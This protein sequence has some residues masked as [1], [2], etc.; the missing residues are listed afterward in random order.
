[1]N[2]FIAQQGWQCPICKTVYSPNT[3]MCYYCNPGATKT[4]TSA[5]DIRWVDKLSVDADGNVR[6]FY[7]N[8]KFNMRGYDWKETL[9]KEAENE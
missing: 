5:S 7:G 8:F 9:D 1:M 4:T 2:E 3:P 6:D